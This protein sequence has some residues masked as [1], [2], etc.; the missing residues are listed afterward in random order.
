MIDGTPTDAPVAPT[1]EPVV[2]T[3]EPIV[4]DPTCAQMFDACATD[5]DCCERLECGNNG[6]VDC[7]W[8]LVW[9]SLAMLSSSTAHLAEFS[10]LKLKVGASRCFVPSTNVRIEV[11]FG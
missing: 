5:D 8:S 11:D 6:K 1:P 3:P 2:P 10:S 9:L 4:G 7:E